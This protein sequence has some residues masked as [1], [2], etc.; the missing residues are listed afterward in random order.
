V[1]GQPAFKA[2]FAL[3]VTVPRAL[4]AVSNMAVAREEPVTPNRKRVAFAPTPKV[5]SYLGS[6]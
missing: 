4:T 2:T 6:N 3:T 1:L 5:S